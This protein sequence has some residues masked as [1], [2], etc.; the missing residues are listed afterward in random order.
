MGDA[1]LGFGYMYQ[2]TYARS[3]GVALE[4]RNDSQRCFVSC[5]GK[6]VYMDIILPCSGDTFCRVSVN[7]VLWFNGVRAV[8]Q[9]ASIEDQLAL[10]A[11][12]LKRWCSAILSGDLS[13]PDARYCFKMS[14]KECDDYIA[15]QTGK[16]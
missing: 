7:Q 9:P 1:L 10:L 5:E 16:E 4:F 12:E 2:G 3:R 11:S 13:C 8:S 6:T 15:A 14:R